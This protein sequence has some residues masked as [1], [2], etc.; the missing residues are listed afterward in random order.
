[1]IATFGEGV[2]QALLPCSWTLLIPAFGLGLATRRPVV[3][4]TFAGVAVLAVWFAVSGWLVPP[5]WVAGTAFLVGGILWWYLGATVAPAA[6]VALGAAWAWQP[7][8]GPALGAALTTAQSDPSA[9]LGGLAAFVS[10]VLVVGL[11]TGLVVGRWSGERLDR[12]GA[13][14]AGLLGVAMVAGIYARIAS[15]FARWSMALWA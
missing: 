4:G 11:A 7:C 15:T 13:I 8:V 12:A 14:V 10:G 2:T 9:A 5:F 3:L 1:M 6:A